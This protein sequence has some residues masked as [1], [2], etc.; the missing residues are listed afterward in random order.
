MDFLG[1]F[2][3]EKRFKSTE[4]SLK[5]DD[6]ISLVRSE[7]YIDSNQVYHR[8]LPILVQPDKPNV[9]MFCSLVI[10]TDKDHS[11]LSLI[12]FADCKCQ[13]DCQTKKCPCKSVDALWGVYSTKH[14]GTNHTHG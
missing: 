4:E 11:N 7:V 8:Q 12:E 10:P 14:D 9:E 13:C 6:F 2:V 1:K 3:N 5:V